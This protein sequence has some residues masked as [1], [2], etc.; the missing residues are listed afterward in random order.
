MD[1]VNE[2]G[3]IRRCN[4]NASRQIGCRYSAADKQTKVTKK[5]KR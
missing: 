3:V 1:R 2:K 4:G 5:L